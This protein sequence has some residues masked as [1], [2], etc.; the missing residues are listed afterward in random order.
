MYREGGITVKVNGNGQVLMAGI[1][2]GTI[3]IFIWYMERAGATIEWISFLRVF[4]SWLILLAFVGWR[5]GWASMKVSPKVMAYCALLG[6]ICHGI[7]N[8]F[9][10]LAVTTI[11]V[12]LSAVLLN[13]ATVFTAVLSAILFSERITPMKGLALGINVLGCILAV[14]GGTLDIASLSLWGLFDGLM[15]GLCYAL[16]AIIG[17]VAG[18]DAD[19]FVMSLWSFFW[20]ALCLLG[21]TLWQQGSL[22]MTPT[23]LGLGFFY[24]LIPTVLGY[25]L[26]YLGL[27]QIE[28]LSRVPVLASLETVAAVILGM[29]LTGDILHL[30]NLVGIAFIIAS[31]W[32]IGK[33]R[34]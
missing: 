26:Y 32:L 14:T 15:A 5:S 2:W 6:I 21:W 29:G 23:L 31:Q 28:D 34:R 20:A 7:Y 10:S 18:H 4:F 30:P 8:I 19:A 33:K 9:Y 1:L 25:I 16:T 11:G 3:G 22:L 17:K 12:S 27:Q 13:A 24:A